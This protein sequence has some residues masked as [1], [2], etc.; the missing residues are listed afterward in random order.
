[1]ENIL[2]TNLHA[3]ILAKKAFFTINYW[4][5]TIL[6]SLSLKVPSVEFYVEARK[7]RVLE[8]RGSLY[9]YYG[10][11]SVATKEM[12]SKFVRECIEQKYVLPEII[13]EYYSNRDLSIFIE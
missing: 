5:S 11:H 12:L 13:D 7:F 9:K 10:I 6:D 2:L 4:G 8:P 1:M 3:A